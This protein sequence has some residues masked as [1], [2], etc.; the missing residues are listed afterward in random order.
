M[1]LIEATGR[2]AA[3]IDR[4]R[5][6]RP[7]GSR[8][9]EIYRRPA[10]GVG[11]PR[12]LLRAG[13]TDDIETVLEVLYP[14]MFHSSDCPASAVKACEVLLAPINTL[15]NTSSV[16][17]S[18]V[19]VTAGLLLGAEDP[20]SACPIRCPQRRRLV[21]PLKVGRTR[22]AAIGYRTRECDVN[23]PRHPLPGLSRL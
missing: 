13:S 9:A 2:A 19:K 15:S 20:S 3:R 16:P 18:P 17:A 12:G 21:D 22:N 5:D 14:L 1:R 4:H 6:N 10:H 23:R 11:C 7:T 8:C